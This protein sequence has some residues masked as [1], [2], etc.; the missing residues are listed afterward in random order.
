MFLLLLDDSGNIILFI[1]T[2]TVKVL[3]LLRTELQDPTRFHLTETVEE[4]ISRF[5][6]TL[7]YVH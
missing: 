5:M 7:L 6:V 2:Y 4:K 3:G 1:A